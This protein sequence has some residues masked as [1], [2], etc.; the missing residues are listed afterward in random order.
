MS[1]RRFKLRP[2]PGFRQDMQSLFDAAM[3]NPR[4]REAR[5]Y[6][7]TIAKLAA[8]QSGT[9]QGTKHLSFMPSYADLSD[10]SEAYV[11][12]D[13]NAKPSHRLIWRTLPP[14][15]PGGLPILEPIVLGDR[16]NGRAFHIAGQRL[17]RPRG[18]S[19]QELDSTPEPLADKSHPQQ[20]PRSERSVPPVSAARRAAQSRAEQTKARRPQIYTPSVPIDYGDADGPEFGD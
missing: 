7:V 2:D 10:C 13:P 16:A 19:L 15:E 11:G 1:S 12:I 9:Y 6:N 5:L 17:G 8:V 3:V 18:V 4:G 14:E 20:A